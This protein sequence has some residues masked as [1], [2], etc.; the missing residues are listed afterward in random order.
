MSTARD[1][2]GNEHE[3]DVL[4]AEIDRLTLACARLEMA[5]LAA[6]DPAERARI[7]LACDAA[8]DALATTVAKLDNLGESL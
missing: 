8:D 4:R 7:G 2:Y 6:D 3:L 5:F 1:L